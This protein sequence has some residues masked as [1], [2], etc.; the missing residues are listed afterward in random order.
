MKVI[1]SRKGFDSAAGGSPSPIFPDGAMLS[2]PIPSRDVDRYAN[3]MC[4]LGTYADML[5]MMMVDQKIVES[6][7]HVDPDL[8]HETKKRKK[9][10]R[11]V[12]GQTGSSLTHLQ[13][14]DVGPGDLYLFFGWF[15]AV[16]QV[17]GKFVF[18]GPDLHVIFGWLQVERIVNLGGGERA[19]EW[20]HSHPHVAGKHRGKHNFLY[21]AREQL[22]FCK[23]PGYGTFKFHESLVL[24]KSGHV[25]SHWN[26]PREIFYEAKIT[27]H[28]NPWKG[29]YFQSAGRGQEFVIA[30]P[31]VAE[32]AESLIDQHA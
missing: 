1:L 2:L 5:R 10:W 17:G 27:Y 8:R 14:N 18:H 16:K 26:L 19:P 6:T 29:D 20:A 13:Q 21:V 25:R 23:Q 24:T 4:G 22:S 31:R 11:G 3:L 32:W 12:F 15:R 7:C 30:D 28:P 9:G